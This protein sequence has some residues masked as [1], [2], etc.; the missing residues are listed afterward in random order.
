ME[1]S[2]RLRCSGAREVDRTDRARGTETKQ[3]EIG[4]F[5]CYG[6]WAG[7]DGGHGT[8]KWADVAGQGV[9]CSSR[10]CE[11]FVDRIGVS[12]EDWCNEDNITGTL[13]IHYDPTIALF[14]SDGTHMLI[15]KTFVDR[16]DVSV[17][18]LGYDLVIS[19]P[20]EAVLTTGVCVRVVV[21]VHDYI[22][23]TDFTMLPMW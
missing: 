23:L 6:F 3:V 10:G 20:T 1:A 19:T 18:N 2:S 5:S 4:Q 15:D 7:S 21:V 11:T 17:E 22:L 13:L 9:C 14:Y 16:I 12:V 8:A